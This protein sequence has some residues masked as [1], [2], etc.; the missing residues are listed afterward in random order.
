MIG[1]DFT[2]IETNTLNSSQ[3]APFSLM[4]DKSDMPDI[5]KYEISLSWVKYSR[6]NRRIS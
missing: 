4:L 5:T 1:T 2:F 6:W 3:K